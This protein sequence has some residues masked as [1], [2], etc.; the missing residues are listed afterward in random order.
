M[1]TGPIFSENFDFAQFYH[2]T[3]W[4]LNP[5]F[6][7]STTNNLSKMRFCIKIGQKLAEISSKEVWKTFEIS[8][9][10]CFSNGFFIGF[11]GETDVF[12]PSF[13]DISA[14]F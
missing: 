6:S 11:W 5:N 4:I 13:D 14:R 1:V 2:E 9:K 12:L 3:F 7:H 8:N 10:S